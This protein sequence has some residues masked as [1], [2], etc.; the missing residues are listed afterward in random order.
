MDS[1]VNPKVMIVEGKRIGVCSLIRNTSGVG[2]CV[3]AP[4]WGLG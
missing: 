2:G 3:G 1:I 4:G